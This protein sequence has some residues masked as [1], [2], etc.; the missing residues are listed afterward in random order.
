MCQRLQYPG[1]QEIEIAFP[2]L[3]AWRVPHLHELDL[4]TGIA[5]G[6]PIDDDG[7]EAPGQK[8][9]ASDPD[10]PRRGIGEKLDGLQALPE[11][12]EDGHAAIEQRAAAFGRFHALAV[13]IEQAYPHSTLQFRDRFGNGRL[14]RVEQGGSLVHAAG[15]DDSHQD[16]QVVQPHAV[17]DAITDLHVITYCRINITL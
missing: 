5:A 10:L 17:S 8:M 13:A 6:E 15:L 11:V 4:D 9:G 1:D 16:M 3:G 7:N 14:G 2:K 12:I